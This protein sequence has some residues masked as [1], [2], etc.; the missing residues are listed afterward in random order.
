[1]AKKS[2]ID[3][4]VNDSQFRAFHEI[5]S[6]F[7]N[8][9]AG[10]SDESKAAFGAVGAGMERATKA[11]KGFHQILSESERVMGKMVK[12]SAELAKNIFGIGKFMMKLT[13]AGVGF[14]AA[15][16]WGLDA[17]GRSAVSNQR[18]AAG[19][20][21]SA[22]QYKAF[23]TDFG[24]YLP[25]GMLA[26]VAGA[27]ADFGRIAYLA[28]AAGVSIQQAQ[29]M[30]VDELS[31]RAAMKAHD[32]WKNTAP[33]LRTQ[34]VMS[35]YGFTQIGMSMEDIR[36][37]GNTPMSALKA[38]SA[39]YGRDT[40]TLQVSPMQTDAWYKLTRQVTLA[41]QTIET[42]LTN[43]LAQLAPTIGA[44][45]KSLTDDFSSLIQSISDKDIQ[46][47]GDGIKA[48][49]DYIGSAAFIDNLKE[50]GNV[51]A[52]ILKA[53]G[54][55]VHAFSAPT[56]K[57]A[58]DIAQYSK[59]QK[60]YSDYKIQS[61]LGLGKGFS[62]GRKSNSLSLSDKEA[63]LAG[64][65]AAYGLPKGTLQSIM[66]AESGNGKHMISPAGAL[67]WFQLMPDTAKQYNADPFDFYESSGA[68]A[69]IMRGNLKTYHG[70]MRKALAAYNWGAGNL[71]KDIS[72]HGADWE[73]YA[74][75]ETRGYIAKIMQ[76]MQDR[77]VNVKITV[78]N[79]TGAS[80]H[81]SNNAAAH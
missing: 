26:N 18:G 12:G 35:S 56:P 23:G 74:P 69:K 24:R 6:Q 58:A 36:R 25:Q 43:K 51:I 67:G 42:V 80:L 52:G 21:L 77:P 9:L 44:V 13:A 41:G 72:Q 66:A 40:G 63:H 64:M 57:E 32:V 53:T 78:E 3:I 54:H 2:I 45:V 71:N 1:M 31:I 37:L 73:K 17:L 38:A 65:D 75:A 16:L 20:S 81:I 8:K 60:A 28:R 4:E 27:Q 22:G 7:E 19:L 10:M 76:A 62:L 48:A 33:E 61:W 50:F 15:G 34:Q 59:S 14:G 39:Q 11:Q 68:A 55:V 5:F 46:R 49:A 70:D 47:L 79:K 30:G 29:N